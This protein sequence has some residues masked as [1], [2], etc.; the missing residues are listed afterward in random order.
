MVA[1]RPA[2]VE[3]RH[4]GEASD[5]EDFSVHAVVGVRLCGGGAELD[6]SIWYEK[7]D[8]E[9][10]PKTG[11]E[12]RCGEGHELEPAKLVNQRILIE[13]LRHNREGTI[14]K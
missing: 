3:M 7:A 10:Y 4:D 1:D 8:G 13:Y 14:S 2:V 6:Q 9:L 5:D 12:W 11:C